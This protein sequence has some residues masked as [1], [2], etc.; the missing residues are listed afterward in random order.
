MNLPLRCRSRKAA[1]VRREAAALLDKARREQDAAAAAKSA[2]TADRAAADEAAAAQRQE[3][4]MLDSTRVR[5]EAECAERIQ[6]LDT[7][8]D[9]ARRS[10]GMTQRLQEQERALQVFSALLTGKLESVLHHTCNCW[11]IAC[12]G[13]VDFAANHVTHVF[14]PPPPPHTH[15]YQH[16][17][18]LGYARQTQFSLLVPGNS[19]D[20]H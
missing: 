16:R 20:F 3:A 11:P 19:S 17:M 8:E 6:Q 10:E 12:Q 14:C 18:G 4:A 2:A 15:L 7:R 13:T 9:V 5:F 1:E